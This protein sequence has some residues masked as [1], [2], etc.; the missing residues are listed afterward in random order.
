MEV[1]DMTKPATDLI[2]EPASSFEQLGGP[3]GISN[4]LSVIIAQLVGSNIAIVDNITG[5]GALDLCRR[6]IVAGVDPDAELHCYRDGVIALRIKSVGAGAKLTVQETASGGPRFSSWR[7]F[8]AARSGRLF[9]K[10]ATT[11]IPGP[12]S[13][14]VSEGVA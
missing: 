14:N 9:V 4:T 3:L 11:S 13:A 1:S 7:P 12:N 6:L 2:G 10:T 5:R 8:P